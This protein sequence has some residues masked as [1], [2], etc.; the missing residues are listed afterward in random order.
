ML[1]EIGF[2][3]FIKNSFVSLK[4]SA[5][6]FVNYF[7]TGTTY[8]SYEHLNNYSELDTNSELS[9]TTTFIDNS[10]PTSSTT[11]PL[12]SKPIR[13]KRFYKR[14]FCSQSYNSPLYPPNVEANNHVLT[15]SIPYQNNKH[16]KGVFF[17]SNKKYRKFNY[18][19]TCIN[20]PI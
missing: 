18:L 5:I 13:R 1:M 8:Q 7:R 6:N 20:Q 3:S 12:K 10:K 14:P 17:R 11:K 2:S 4:N 19:N 15:N 9:T 16:C